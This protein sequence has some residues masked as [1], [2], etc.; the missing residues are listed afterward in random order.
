MPGAQA[1]RS[2]ESPSLQDR[3][4]T[5]T[6]LESLSPMKPVSERAGDSGS[7]AARDLVAVARVALQHDD[8]RFALERAKPDMQGKLASFARS[9]QMVGKTCARRE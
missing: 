5:V 9:L 8:A 2:A 6:P 4:P 1:G 7:E 3:A